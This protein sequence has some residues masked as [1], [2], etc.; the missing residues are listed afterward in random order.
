LFPAITGA[1]HAITE[2]VFVVACD[3]PL[4]SLNLNT[5]AEFQATS[6]ALPS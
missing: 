5:P 6:D 4:R 1:I 2:L 3:M